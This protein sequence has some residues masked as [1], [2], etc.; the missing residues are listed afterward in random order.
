MSLYELENLGLVLQT[1]T[2]FGFKKE[3]P[4]LFQQSMFFFN[5]L[6]NNIAS[7]IKGFVTID[8]IE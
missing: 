5:I 3:Y 6:N 7:S 2:S 1:L 4:D 8:A